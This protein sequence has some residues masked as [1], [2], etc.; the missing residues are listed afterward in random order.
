MEQAFGLRLRGGTQRRRRD[1]L[2]TIYATRSN[3]THTGVSPTATGAILR[4]A[5]AGGMRVALLSNLVQGALLADSLAPRSSLIG[6][7]FI[8]PSH[9]R[10]SRSSPIQ[11]WS[12]VEQPP[13]ACKCT[14]G[15]SNNFAPSEVESC[16]PYAGALEQ[17]GTR[18]GKITNS[19]FQLSVR[20]DVMEAKSGH[21]PTFTRFQQT[22]V[23]WTGSDWV[24]HPRL[25]PVDS[26]H[27][28]GRLSTDR[29]PM[30]Y[31]LDLSRILFRVRRSPV[32]FI[33]A[34]PSA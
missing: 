19:L 15:E 16:P 20:E 1:L 8:D 25:K 12:S 32:C 22:E 18:R 31:L 5:D 14:F 21:P 23:K 9:I 2:D 17:S 7:P 30:P 34:M 24:E 33:S 13:T 4:L 10:L 28:L 27:R 26:Q 3:P 6:H 29:E 11:A